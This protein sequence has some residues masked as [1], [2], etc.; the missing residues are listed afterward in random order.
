MTQVTNKVLLQRAREMKDNPTYHEKVFKGLLRE[1]RIPFMTQ[2][3]IGFYI[4]DFLIDKTIVELDGKSHDDRQEYDAKRDRYLR[5]NGYKVIR[6]KNEVVR[7]FKFSMFDKYVNQKIKH[8]VPKLKINNGP[9]P[10]SYIPITDGKES[11]KAKRKRE[12]R[13]MTT[14][15]RKKRDGQQERFVREA[16]IYDMIQLPNGDFKRVK[17]K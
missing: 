11:G 10:C 15:I 5:A 7:M 6:I 17:R 12:Q 9:K 1:R 2:I 4:V 3:V 8:K 14:W 13:N 16:A